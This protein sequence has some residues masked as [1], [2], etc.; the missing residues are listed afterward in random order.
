M[1]NESNNFWSNVTGVFDETP[2]IIPNN[3]IVTAQVKGIKYKDI[4]IKGEVKVDVFGEL[5]P[6]ISKESVININWKIID[7]EFE[8]RLLWQNLYIYSHD[9]KRSHRSKNFLMRLYNLKGLLLPSGAPLDSDLK[10]LDGQIYNIKIQI[11]V[12]DGISTNWVSEVH[13]NK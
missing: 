12:K 11:M 10:D 2:S 5:T 1:L 13:E 9:V 6:T 4:E 7:R 8:N 3:T